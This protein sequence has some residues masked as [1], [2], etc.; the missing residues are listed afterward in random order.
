MALAH[1]L[2]GSGIE[3]AALAL[4]TTR[5]PT[6]SEHPLLVA[7]RAIPLADIA[8]SLLRKDFVPGSNPASQELLDCLRRAHFNQGGQLELSRPV[9]E[10]QVELS[11]CRL[12]GVPCDWNR[13]YRLLVSALS[14]AGHLLFDAPCDGRTLSWSSYTRTHAEAAL[15]RGRARFRHGRALR[16]RPGPKH[17]HAGLRS[18]ARLAPRSVHQPNDARRRPGF[19]A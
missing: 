2:S 14:D 18:R 5:P 17:R 13:A 6:R 9:A 8:L 4:L 3:T 12:A 19:V 15:N 7:I 1:T 16:L 11:K 10:I